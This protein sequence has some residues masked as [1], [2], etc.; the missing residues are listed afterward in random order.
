MELNDSQV[1]SITHMLCQT[2]DRNSH[3]HEYT[4]HFVQNR[5][6]TLAHSHVKKLQERNRRSVEEAFTVE[7]FARVADLWYL[8]SSDQFYKVSATSEIHSISK[9]T[10]FVSFKKQLSNEY[11]DKRHVLFR[12]LVKFIKKYRT[13]DKFVPAN[14]MR[15]RVIELCSSIIDG[16]NNV[17]YFLSVLGTMFLKQNLDTTEHVW[18]G[19]GID[20][21]RMITSYI[22]T[23]YNLPS[24]TQIA[25]L[26]RSLPAENYRIRHVL[27]I[28][29]PSSTFIQDAIDVAH[30][31]V[32]VSLHIAQNK[33]TTVRPS[34]ITFENESDLLKN[35]F[36]AC[37]SVDQEETTHITDLAEHLGNYVDAHNLP[38]N[39]VPKVHLA[40]FLQEYAVTRS[41]YALVSRYSTSCTQTSEFL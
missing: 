3:T 15:T 17:Y 38:R 40:N 26:C 36:D 35:F 16:E 8:P 41:R 1:A 37:C 2:M 14:T 30:L 5:L 7:E 25:K 18:I 34:S 13:L 27:H 33:N 32:V 28:K 19:S 31:I 39:L 22:S 4:E 20:V 24:S 23:T 12:R 10:I 29:T 9:D 21:V 6:T 11:Y